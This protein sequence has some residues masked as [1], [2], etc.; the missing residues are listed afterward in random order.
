MASRRALSLRADA[1]GVRAPRP[2]PS[3]SF[4]CSSISAAMISG[5]MS[6]SR[7]NFCFDM[8]ASSSFILT[9]IPLTSDLTSW[10]TKSANRRQPNCNSLR[11]S[12][13]LKN[14][15]VIG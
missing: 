8:N 11:R 6:S 15:A 12:K 1:P 5:V 4:L 10:T 14:I 9:D 2:A 13:G 7:G 3:K